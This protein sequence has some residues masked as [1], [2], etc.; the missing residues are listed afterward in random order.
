MAALYGRALARDFLDIDLILASGRYSRRRL[1]DLAAAADPGFDLRMFASALG[2]LTQ[3]TG[4]AFA[5]YGHD[6]RRHHCPAASLR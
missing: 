1:L 6:R 4:A 5:E 3:I 2:A